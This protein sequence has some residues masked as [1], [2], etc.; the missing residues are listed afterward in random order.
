MIIQY[1]KKII[2]FITF[3]ICNDCVIVNVN[4]IQLIYQLEFV[5]LNKTENIFDFI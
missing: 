4:F 5:F 1:R 2:H 3:E